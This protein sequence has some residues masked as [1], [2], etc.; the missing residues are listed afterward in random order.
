[1]TTCCRLIEICQRYRCKEAGGSADKDDYEGWLKKYDEI[2]GTSP[3]HAREIYNAVPIHA[4]ISTS[5]QI[6]S[7]DVPRKA[8]MDAYRVLQRKNNLSLLPKVI[9]RAVD[10]IKSGG[11]LTASTAEEL[12]RRERGTWKPGP[13]I[14]YVTCENCHETKR[15]EETV[16][17]N[18]HT[19][20]LSCAKEVTLVGKPQIKDKATEYK[21]KDTWS[22][23]KS[24]MSLPESRVD[25][26]G[27]KELQARGHKV[28]Y[29]Q[30]VCL[31]WTYTE[32]EVDEK[33]WFYNDGEEVHEGK[34]DRDTELRTLLA[35]VTHK[36][37]YGIPYKVH[38]KKN[39]KEIVD[40]IEEKVGSP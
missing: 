18:G 15:R 31:V 39:V 34:E 3:N 7:V 10:V 1:M 6:C 26:D 40:F 5:L 17:K 2:C 8:S 4:E 33:A 29:G 13:V 12:V 32:Y 28:K 36:P 20:C 37:V 35:E 22:Y 38:S 14:Q 30:K 23:R 21:P 25:I 24:Q 16:R 9:P 11:E 19:Y 27:L